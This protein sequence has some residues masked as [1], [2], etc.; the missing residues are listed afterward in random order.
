MVPPPR[1]DASAALPLRLVQLWLRA[2]QCI[3]A[4]HVRVSEVK[5]EHLEILLHPVLLGGTGDDALQAAGQ[6]GKA[7]G[8]VK[9]G[10]QGRAPGPSSHVVV[11]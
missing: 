6:G 4:L 5:I 8:Q 10:H 1:C 11:R 3:D 2:I 9:G 7:K